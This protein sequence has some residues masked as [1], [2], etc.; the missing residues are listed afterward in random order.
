MQ[1]FLPQFEGHIA[2]PQIP[3]DF[4]ARV[5]E[6]VRTGLIAPGSRRRAEYEVES[7]SADCI[8]FRATALSTAI[9]VGLNEVVVERKAAEIFYRARYWRWT[10]YCVTLGAVLF[11]I[12]MAGSFVWPQIAG[13]ADRSLL[14][15]HAGF[16][17]LVWPWLLTAM[18]KRFAARCLERI[19]RELL[20]PSPQS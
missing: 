1:F 5:A 18:H 20:Q 2:V 7:L 15:L 4:T 16:W 6:R 19:L 17:G 12:L 8:A 9:A 3:R 10:L 11:V 13:S 14:F